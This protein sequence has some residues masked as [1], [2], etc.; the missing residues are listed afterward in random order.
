MTLPQCVLAARSCARGGT[1]GRL[2]LAAGK[3][4]K[5]QKI[6]LKRQASARGWL[7]DRWRGVADCGGS[8][9][10]DDAGRAGETVPQAS[11]R[12]G[13]P[14]LCPPP[15]RGAGGRRRSR[16]IASRRRPN[17]PRETL[18][19]KAERGV[20]VRCRETGVLSGLNVG[21]RRM[22][23]RIFRPSAGRPGGN[24]AVHPPRIALL[25]LGGVAKLSARTTRRGLSMRHS[26]Q[27]ATFGLPTFARYSRRKKIV[28]T[29]AC[30]AHS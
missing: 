2:A 5:A 18:L 1:G 17:A 24:R 7:A 29:V 14:L 19:V 6:G 23:L 28:A 16:E 9:R 26:S 8:Y 15:G 20:R 25:Q 13:R 21:G 30:E 12:P 11:C 3:G 22:S 27:Y 10:S 4:A